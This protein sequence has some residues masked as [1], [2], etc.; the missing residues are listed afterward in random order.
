MPR[1][2]KED[3]IRKAR[4]L[5]LQQA[6]KGGVLA[7]ALGVDERTARAYA[8]YVR[9][10]AEH[11]AANGSG[12]DQT[13]LVEPCSADAARI[14]DV[15]LEAIDLT[16]ETQ[17]RVAIHGDVVNEYAECMEEG[18]K[19]PVVILFR[20]A[21]GYWVG[22]GF[23]RIHAAK[24]VGFTA[25]RAEV[26][27]GGPREAFLY[28]C[29]ANARHGLRPTAVDKRHAVM[30]LLMDEKWGQWSD[31]EIARRCVVSHPFV[32]KI[33]AELDQRQ[34]TRDERLTGNITSE[35]VYTTKHGTM[36][37]MDT[38]N[39]GRRAES[40]APAPEPPA[41][42]P[43]PRA[44]QPADEPRP[45]AIIYRWDT[46]PT[47]SPAPAHGEPYRIIRVQDEPIDPPPGGW[48]P[49]TLQLELGNLRGQ[50]EQY[51][52][53]VERHG[54]LTAVLA[55]WTPAERRDFLEAVAAI[56]AKWTVFTAEVQRAATEGRVD[57]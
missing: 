54:G 3:L 42:E 11:A 53:A 18:E 50:V 31:R 30:R 46:S 32:G 49:Y 15:P 21:E 39:I 4:P 35:R 12:S 25:I 17:A 37:I 36:A 43:E 8:R 5:V 44:D 23:H 34:V 20:D 13:P 2:L 22:D 52:Q 24:K 38:T 26:R 14:E 16:A 55:D 7:E 47:T 1:K 6:L 48:R 40:P 56:E 57:G 33:R 41:G 9:Q 29:A 51:L 45:G 27:E 19:F 28:A 10:E